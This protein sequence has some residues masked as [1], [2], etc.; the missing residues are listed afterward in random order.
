LKILNLKGALYAFLTRATQNSALESLSKCL[1]ASGCT[2]A[3]LNV[4]CNPIG[5]AILQIIPFLKDITNLNI[6][7]IGMEGNTATE[8]F[9]H[10]NPA[11][12]ALNLSLNNIGSSISNLNR[13]SSLEVLDIS[14]NR[15][16]SD[17]LDTFLGQL[18]LTNLREINFSDNGSLGNLQDGWISFCNV[19]LFMKNL[20]IL[21]VGDIGLCQNQIEELLRLISQKK[22]LVVLFRHW[23]L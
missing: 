10:L 17:D 22:I 3:E 16:P 4:S 9:I 20:S 21:R 18:T 11:I 2:L 1:K 13:F 23:I 7:D 6:S 12:K 19:L 15:V 14:S 8:L 5:A